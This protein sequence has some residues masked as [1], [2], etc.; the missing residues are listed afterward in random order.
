MK[1]AAE[2]LR[3]AGLGSAVIAGEL[4]YLRPDGKRPR[5]HDVSRVA[6][7][8]AT[9]A[10]LD[11]LR[12][13]PF[14]IIEI[15]GA[16]PSGPFEQT[17]Q[18]LAGIFGAGRHCRLP[19]AVGLK[20]AAEVE[21]LFYQWVDKGAEGIVVRNDAVGM[22]KIKPR[23]SI[24]AVVIGFTEGTDDRQG[25]IH[26]LLIALMRADGCLHVLGHVERR[27]Q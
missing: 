25:M 18:R 16:S 27:V 12:F 5:V 23:H 3:K 21:K 19:A 4:Y 1:E 9:V 17:W 6:R 20:D 14:D 15:D 11:G 22:F 13:A 10:E 8:P 26:D 24:D 7:Q 2:L